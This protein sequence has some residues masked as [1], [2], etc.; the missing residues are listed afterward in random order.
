[1]RSRVLRVEEHE[2]NANHLSQKAI[3]LMKQYFIITSTLVV[4]VL[5]TYGLAL[6]LKS[7]FASADY[8]SVAFVAPESADDYSFAITNQTKATGFTYTITHGELVSDPVSVSVPSGKA[9]VAAPALDEM[10]LSDNSALTITVT[11]NDEKQT[12][13]K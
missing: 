13:H 10:S 9:Y 2:R 4:F 12:L 6:N 11:H 7:Q 8:W 3:K 1:M 5:M